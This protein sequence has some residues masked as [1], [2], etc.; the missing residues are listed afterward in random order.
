MVSIIKVL[1]RL[2]GG[3][4]V[5]VGVMESCISLFCGIKALCSIDLNLSYLDYE[6]GEWNKKK[7]RDDLYT[8]KFKV[9]ERDVVFNSL[10]Y[11]IICLLLFP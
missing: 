9:F 7:M 8:Q 5:D 11:L 2:D 3:A 1:V 6:R 4:R 10:R